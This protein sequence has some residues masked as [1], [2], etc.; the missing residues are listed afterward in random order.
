MTETLEMMSCRSRSFSPE[1]HALVLLFFRFGFSGIMP[2][3]RAEISSARRG[4]WRLPVRWCGL[5]LRPDRGRRRLF[6]GL[7]VSAVYD[8]IFVVLDAP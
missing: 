2:H 3:F 1:V 8:N 6:A 4:A 7:G 5:G